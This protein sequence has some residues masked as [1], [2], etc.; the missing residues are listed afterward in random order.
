M[1]EAVL[2]SAAFVVLLISAF[3]DIRTR[4]V[5]DWLNFSGIAAGL[6]IRTLWSLMSDEWSALGWGLLGFLVFL[7][8]ALMMYYTGQWGGGDSKLMMALGALLGFELSLNAISVA[9]LIWALFAGAAYGLVWSAWLASRHWNT[10]IR[11]YSAL[12]RS[13]RWAHLPALGVLVLGFAFAIA[14]DDQIFRIIMLSLALIVPVL[15]YTAL[16]V[17]AVEQ[18]CMYKSMSPAQLTEGDWIARQVVI[19]GR[20]VT[21]PKDL[22]I[23]KGKIKELQRSNVKSVIVKEGIPFVPSFLIA[24]LISVLVGSPLQWFF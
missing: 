13:V 19:N 15:F 2:L 1:L 18:C 22:G 24:L 6:G 20:Y 5:P 3:T 12:S 14:S 23:T 4:E 10:F 9:F 21:G 7:G 17:K 16:G 11:R 8:I